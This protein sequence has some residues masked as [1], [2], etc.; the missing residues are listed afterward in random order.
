MFVYGNY[1]NP[2]RYLFDETSKGG[3]KYALEN[4]PVLKTFLFLH[5]S[6]SLHLG[7]TTTIKLITVDR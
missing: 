7:K 3:Y 4:W 6:Y 2:T 1:I 5:T